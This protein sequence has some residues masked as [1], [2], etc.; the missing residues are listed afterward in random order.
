VQKPIYRT[1]VVERH[2]AAR[3]VLVW[4]RLVDLLDGGLVRD[5]GVAERVLSFE[6]PWRRAARL[7]A[8]SVR[9]AEHTVALR[10]DG[11]DTHVV[12]ALVA[13]VAPPGAPDAADDAQVE[14]ALA[15]LRD[16][17][18]SWADALAAPPPANW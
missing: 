10:D 15:P 5:A 9:F 6:P 13:E 8:A 18:T 11:D 17:V 12:W 2:V 14:A 1:F 3:R 7:D 4:D 16:A